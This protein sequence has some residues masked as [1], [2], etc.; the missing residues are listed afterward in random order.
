VLHSGLDEL[1]DKPLVSPRLLEGLQ[2]TLDVIASLTPPPKVD[3]SGQDFEPIL[4]ELR[5]ACS[6]KLDG[7]ANNAYDSL[8]NILSAWL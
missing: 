4:R 7:N 2:D 3:A 1:R 5:Q 6:Q 8:K